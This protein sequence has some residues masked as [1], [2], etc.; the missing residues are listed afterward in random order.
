[1]EI[2]MCTTHQYDNSPN[3]HFFLT[4]YPQLNMSTSQIYKCREFTDNTDLHIATIV[5]KGK[6]RIME[7]ATCTICGK[8]KNRFV[9]QD[10]SKLTGIPEVA[11]TP[12]LI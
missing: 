9:K 7:K 6:D 10:F 11:I 4:N 8:K 1:M 12:E 5:T 2:Y 3:A